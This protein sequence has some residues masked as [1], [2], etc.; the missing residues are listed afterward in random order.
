MKRFLTKENLLSF[1]M[2]TAG[3]VTAAFAIEEFL[4]PTRVF[5]GGVV[6]VGMILSHFVPLPTIVL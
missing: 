2:L 1:L 5:D 4:T 6:G 3:A